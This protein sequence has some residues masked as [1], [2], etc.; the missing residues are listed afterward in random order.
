MSS[1]GS[2]ERRCVSISAFLAAFSATAISSAEYG[3]AAYI[4]ARVLQGTRMASKI[5]PVMIALNRD[6]MS[7][8]ADPPQASS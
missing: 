3:L 2:P 5:E 1:G 7:D 4:Y 6:L 8:P